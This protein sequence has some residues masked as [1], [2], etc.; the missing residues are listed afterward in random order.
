MPSDIISHNRVGKGFCFWGAKLKLSREEVKHIALLARL[1]LT[2]SDVEKFREQL[3]NILENFEILKQVDTTDVPP[4]SHPVALTNVLRED[5]VAPSYPPKEILANA[6]QE[7]DGCF[8]VRA[9]LE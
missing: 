8:R 7:E 9:V 4:T 1:G 6:P 3:S 5:E 2:E